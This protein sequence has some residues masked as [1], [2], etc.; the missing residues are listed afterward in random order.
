MT[1]RPILF[2]DGDCALCNKAVRIVLRFEGNTTMLFASLQSDI[3]DKML[4]DF[5]S[6][7][8][9]PDSII[10]LHEGVVYHKSSAILKLAALSGG[11]LRL[12]KVVYIFPRRWRDSLYDYIAVSRKK[13]FGKSEHCG[14]MPEVDRSRFVDL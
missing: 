13:W 1:N 7:G 8:S 14:L 9:R 2:F 12:M 10:L 4:S 6:N 5:F 11:W 3:A